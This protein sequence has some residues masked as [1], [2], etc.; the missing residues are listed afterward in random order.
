MSYENFKKITP[1]KSY[2]EALE[3]LTP[4]EVQVLKLVRKGY[5]SKRIAREL[6]LSDRTVQ[7]H[8]NNICKK[9]KLKGRNGLIMWILKVRSEG[10]G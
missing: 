1:K 10:K 4:R 5:T 8:R 7:N 6:Y 2:L 9:L 3:V